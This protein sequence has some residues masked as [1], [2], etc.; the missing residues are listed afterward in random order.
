MKVCS[1]DSSIALAVH[2]A[3]ARCSVPSLPAAATL[4][5]AR[6]QRPPGALYRASCT[7]QSKHVVIVLKQLL[8]GIL[9]N[10]AAILLQ[11]HH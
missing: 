2:D 4:V 7:G 1:R 3:G 6:R 9:G 11:A 10:D 5:L 8:I